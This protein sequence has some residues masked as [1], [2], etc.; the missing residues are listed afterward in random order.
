MKRNVNSLIIDRCINK[1]LRQKTLDTGVDA[2]FIP[3]DCRILENR[4]NGSKF[5]DIFEYIQ[6]LIEQLLCM[7]NYSWNLNL[8]VRYLDIKFSFIDEFIM[9][10]YFMMMK[11]YS[12]SK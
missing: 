4:I 5:V 9:G 8:E 6:Q 11:L 1:R 3:P 2:S 10:V 12:I 7:G